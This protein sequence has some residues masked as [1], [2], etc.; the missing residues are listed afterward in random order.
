ML[1]ILKLTVTVPRERR[2]LLSI[3]WK[4]MV[5]VLPYGNANVGCHWK[6]TVPAPEAARVTSVKIKLRPPVLGM[7]GEAAGEVLGFW[8]PKAVGFIIV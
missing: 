3:A 8:I 5:L 2:P 1:G 4:T 6:L 7:A